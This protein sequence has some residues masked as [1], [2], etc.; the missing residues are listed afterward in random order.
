MTI[1]ERVDPNE[2]TKKYV[3]Y[4][5][6]GII[7]PPKN[8]EK[9]ALIVAQPHEYHPHPSYVNQR[10]PDHAERW[11]DVYQYQIKEGS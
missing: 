5:C 7:L 8:G 6:V 9:E 2:E 4:R 10:C 11:H 1:D 3:P